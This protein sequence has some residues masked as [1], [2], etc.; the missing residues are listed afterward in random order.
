MGMDTARLDEIPWELGITDEEISERKAFL[1]FRDDD[2]A[3]LKALDMGLAIDTF[4]HDRQKTIKR[5]MSQLAALNQVA[6]A[7]ISSL[8]LKHVL[9]EVMRCAIDFIYRAEATMRMP[10]ELIY[11]TFPRLTI[12]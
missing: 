7:I 3:R 6:G 10:R 12:R 1:D 8:R 11:A 5:K 4:L 9:D 2:L